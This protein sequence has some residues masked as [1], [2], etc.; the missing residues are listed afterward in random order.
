MSEPTTGIE[1]HCNGRGGSQV[2]SPMVKVWGLD[3]QDGTSVPSQ[4]RWSLNIWWCFLS[5]TPCHRHV[6][7]PT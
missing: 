1:G 7:D 2:L 5:V 6:E 4:E 3:C